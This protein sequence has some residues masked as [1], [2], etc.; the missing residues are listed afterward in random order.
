M[1][2][3]FTWLVLLGLFAGL[4]GNV[5]AADPCDVLVTMHAM[6]HAGHHHDPSKPCDPSHD[7]KCPLEH[8]HHDACCHSMPLAVE[9]NHQSRL[10]G[11][12]FSLMPVRSESQR[13]PDGPFADL[14]KPP[15]I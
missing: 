3:I 2:W 13:L 6:E 5:L 12:G 1:K 7:Q 4:P 9:D 11:L 15:L 10:G 8:H 14:D